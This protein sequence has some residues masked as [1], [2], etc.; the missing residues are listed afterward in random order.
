M[1]GRRETKLRWSFESFG[2]TGTAKGKGERGMTI[3]Y[4]RREARREREGGFGPSMAGHNGGDHI[5]Q[6]GKGRGVENEALT[7]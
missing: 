5:M 3:L 4:P 6:S 1:N 7:S 2:S